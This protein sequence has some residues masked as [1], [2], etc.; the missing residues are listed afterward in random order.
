MFVGLFVCFACFCKQ[1]SKHTKT[2]K[3]LFV[4]LFACLFVCVFV[5]MFVC[6]FVCFVSPEWLKSQKMGFQKKPYS[7][8][9]RPRGV[10]NTSTLHFPIGL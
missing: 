9:Q 6:L 1:N 8:G 7:P 10:L 2:S 5:C 4:S 3:A